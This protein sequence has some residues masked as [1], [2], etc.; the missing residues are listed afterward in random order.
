MVQ[1]VLGLL[2][3]G[4]LA[5][6]GGRGL[7]CSSAMAQSKFEYTRRYEVE[8]KL[9]PNTWIVVRV[10]GKGFHKATLTFIVICRN[11]KGSRFIPVGVPI[12]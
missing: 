1:T 8:D 9:L 4:G 12:H 3:V 11:V 10:D 5:L 2:R 6:R 7:S